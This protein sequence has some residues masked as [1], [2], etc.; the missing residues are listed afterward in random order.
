[1]DLQLNIDQVI[2]EENYIHFIQ[3][4]KLDQRKGEFPPQVKNLNDVLSKAICEELD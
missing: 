1:M 3:K 4:R 2:D